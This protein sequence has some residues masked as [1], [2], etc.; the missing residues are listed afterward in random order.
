MPKRSRPDDVSDPFV[1]LSRIGAEEDAAE[2]RR[3]EL[4]NRRKRDAEDDEKI[5]D[6]IRDWRDADGSGT[7]AEFLLKL[8]PGDPAGALFLGKVYAAVRLLLGRYRMRP[9]DCAAI[10][11]QLAKDFPAAEA[12]GPAAAS[13]QSS[14]AKPL[15]LPK[16]PPET[17]LERDKEDME[18]PAEF[19]RRVYGAW[20]GR[21]LR[22]RDIS[23]LDPPLYRALA[24]WV[25]RHPED[26]IPELVP[27]TDTVDA[28]V[29]KLAD[30][31]TPDELRRL[32][33]ALQSRYRRAKKTP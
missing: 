22:R 20:I 31:M 11:R 17:W 4:R 23:R 28:Q 1:P 27:N 21:G 26:D 14:A 29:A 12:E 8:F 18:S 25:H 32:G 33:L 13:A 5:A 30:H 7:D 3:Q 2:E 6:L 10:V 9:A 16:T 24:V 15:R 19:T